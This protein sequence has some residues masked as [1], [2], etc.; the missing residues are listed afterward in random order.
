MIP[1]ESH[2]EWNQYYCSNIYLFKKP[3]WQT[4][5]IQIRLCAWSTV[6]ASI[7]NASGMLGNYLQQATSANDI[8]RCIFLGALRVK[9]NTPYA[10]IVP[11]MKLS[12]TMNGEFALRAT[13]QI[14]CSCDLDL[15]CNLHTIGNWKMPNMYAIGLK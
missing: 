1:G 13:G 9:S 14:L 3:L 15:R 6:F 4:R 5:W 7:V 11:N 12:S 2:N 10:I 8:F